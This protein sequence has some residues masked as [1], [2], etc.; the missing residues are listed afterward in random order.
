MTTPALPPPVGPRGLALRAIGEGLAA[1]AT[2]QP[3]TA[4]PYSRGRGFTRRAW[5]TGY[6]R[7]RLN[8]DLPTVTL[9]EDDSA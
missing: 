8:A 2:D 4:C 5:L 9:D 1:G 3:V 6:V 7:G